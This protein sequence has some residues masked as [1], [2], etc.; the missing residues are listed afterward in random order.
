MNQN[1]T[2]TEIPEDYDA[3]ELI[4]RTRAFLLAHERYSKSEAS[5]LLDKAGDEVNKTLTAPLTALITPKSPEHAQR[6]ATTRHGC[7]KR[8]LAMH[9]TPE[10]SEKEV[11]NEWLRQLWEEQHTNDKVKPRERPQDPPSLKPALYTPKGGRKVLD[12]IIAAIECTSSYIEEGLS[13]I[14]ARLDTISQSLRHDETSPPQRRKDLYRLHDSIR[15]AFC[16]AHL[17]KKIPSREQ[18][19]EWV[20]KHGISYFVGDIRY[21]GWNK[22]V[23]TKRLLD[24]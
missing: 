10:E 20:F 7:L 24:A 8:L 17:G 16:N 21:N 5:S 12:P 19:L 15:G 1:S 9:S 4:K 3:M 6:L 23:Y 18:G 11:E 14:D 22:G 2:M 13:T